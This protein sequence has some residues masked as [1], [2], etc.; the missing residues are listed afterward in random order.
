MLDL[1]PKKI[2]GII[3]DEG[4]KSEAESTVGVLIEMPTEFAA[5]FSLAASRGIVE[6]DGFM[7]AGLYDGWLLHL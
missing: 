6:A 5:S 7:R 2:E 1:D 4:G 3:W